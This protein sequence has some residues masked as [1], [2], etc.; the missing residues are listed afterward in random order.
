MDVLARLGLQRVGKTPPKPKPKKKR[1]TK[2]DMLDRARAKRE[3]IVKDAELALKIKKLAIEEAELENRLAEIRDGKAKKSEESGVKALLREIKEQREL[4]EEIGKLTGQTKA[5]E[6]SIGG[7]LRELMDSEAGAKLAEGLM[8][9]ASPMLARIFMGDGKTP[10]PTPEVTKPRQLDGPTP[11]PEPVQTNG[12]DAPEEATLSAIVDAIKQNLDGNLPAEAANKLSRAAQLNKR[13]QALIREI[14]AI[15]ATEDG[16]ATF[17]A[18]KIREA[19][20]NGNDKDAATISDLMGW[21]SEPGRFA[22]SV[23]VVGELKK[24]HHAPAPAAKK[25]GF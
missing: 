16:L 10:A 24:L 7:I 5:P 8:E 12:Q 3:S 1:A 18:G 21:L 13:Y 25:S 6:S 2:A 19:Q 14:V 11:E 20:Q 15:P 23:Q 22:W 9:V 17:A 4:F